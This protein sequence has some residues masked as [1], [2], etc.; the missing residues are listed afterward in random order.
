M[1][2]PVL[3]ARSV[4]L[5]TMLGLVALADKVAPV[6]LIDVPLAM[7]VMSVQLTPPSTEPYRM[8]PVLRAALSVALMVC[9][10][11]EVFWSLELVPVSALRV[12][13]L[14]VRVGTVLSS[15]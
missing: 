14:T 2:A 9:A 5:K 6:Q 15:T 11:V 13:V 12:M 7:L 3:P 4:T 8:S 1:L 10:A